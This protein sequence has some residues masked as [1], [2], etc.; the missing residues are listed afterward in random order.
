ML[1][2]NGKET[3]RQC[4]DC[5]ETTVQT[6]HAVVHVVNVAKVRISIV[7][8]ISKQAVVTCK[9]RKRQ[10]SMITAATAEM[11]TTHQ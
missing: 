6:Y 5:T 4:K 1:S 10:V 3:S 11:A 7:D 8:V 9:R 2:L